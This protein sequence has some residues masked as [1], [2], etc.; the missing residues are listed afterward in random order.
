MLGRL[1]KPWFVYHP[2]Q[3]IR[4]TVGMAFPPS[5]GF[6]PI[7]TSWGG[8]I[9]ADPSR[10]IGRSIL[11]TGV[12]DLAVSEAL[13]R[14]IAP[15]DTVIDAGA[16]V[17]YMTVLSAIAAGPAGR[18][19][20]FEPHPALFEVLRQ[21]IER[22]RRRFDTAVTDVRHAALGE[23]SGLATLRIPPDFA[24]N[25][26]V[27]MLVPDSQKDHNS[28]PVTVET[29]DDVLAAGSA[30]VLKL[31]VEG[32]EESV[33]RGA[34]AALGQRRIRHIVFEDH[35]RT[36]SPVVERLRSAGYQVF[37]LGW[38]MRGIVVR[39]IEN[40]SLEKYYEAPNFIAT[41]S[42]DEML[43]RCSPRGWSILTR[44]RFLARH[45]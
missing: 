24:A 11:T 19:V 12:Y 1:W 14:L 36:A 21:N 23:S 43:N 2:T 27:A 7:E 38:S 41:T 31:D 28:I 16:N 5:P 32:F 34:P 39:P 9:L 44:R 4:R 25:D 22:V 6:R 35:H 8:S 42:P 3:L 45:R 17:G 40:G 10:A 29:L 18:V 13:A 20:A 30:A 33:L 15:G 26:G 37:S